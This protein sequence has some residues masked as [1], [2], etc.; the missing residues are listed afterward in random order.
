[1]IMFSIYIEDIGLMLL[2]RRNIPHRFPSLHLF[3]VKTNESSKLPERSSKDFLASHPSQKFIL[4]V[5]LKSDV[6]LTDSGFIPIVAEL[7]HLAKTHDPELLDQVLDAWKAIQ[8]SPIDPL[9]LLHWPTDELTPEELILHLRVE[10]G[11][12]GVIVPLVVLLLTSLPVLLGVFLGIV[13]LGMIFQVDW[14]D[15]FFLVL[16]IV[17]LH[18][19]FVKQ[20]VLLGSTR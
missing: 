7:H 14:T 1:M 10:V 17:V 19:E 16:I 6:E 11:R 20:G 5:N 12:K 8:I 18:L 15:P 2:H 13:H 9:A 3:I 4:H